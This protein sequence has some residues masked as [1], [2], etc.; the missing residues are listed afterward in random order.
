M[1]VDGADALKFFVAAD[2]AETCARFLQNTRVNVVLSQRAKCDTYPP[3]G[4]CA[5]DR[6]IRL[7][8]P[9]TWAKYGE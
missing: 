7:A 9:A 6:P 5:F 4:I 2:D 8:D 1:D 3:N